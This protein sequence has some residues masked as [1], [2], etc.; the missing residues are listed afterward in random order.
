MGHRNGQMQ[1]QKKINQS[2]PSLSNQ[3]CEQN[4]RYFYPPHEWNTVEAL[5]DYW[6]KNNVTV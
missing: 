4:E 3:F 5:M 6:H 1:P 2:F